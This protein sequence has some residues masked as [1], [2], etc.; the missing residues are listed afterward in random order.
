[1]AFQGLL[2]LEY[3]VVLKRTETFVFVVGLLHVLPPDS[4]CQEEIFW[5]D[6]NSTGVDGTQVSIVEQ[7]DKVCLRRLLETQYRRRLEPQVCLEILGD[8][9]HHP[10]EGQ[11]SDEQCCAPLEVTNVLQSRSPRSVPVG[12]Y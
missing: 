7:P 6:G 2:L 10:L 12:L 8:F 11:L 1:M 5:H 4:P 9:P 3:V